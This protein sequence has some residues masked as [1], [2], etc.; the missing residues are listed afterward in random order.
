VACG[1]RHS[2]FVTAEGALLVCGRHDHGVLG[3]GQPAPSLEELWSAAERRLYAGSGHHRG[4]PVQRVPVTLCASGV[5]RVACGPAH[6][7]VCTTAGQ[8]RTTCRLVVRWAA[9]SAE[10]LPWSASCPGARTNQVVR[11]LPRAY[12]RAR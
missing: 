10:L 5:A 2:A 11:E 9:A 12:H 6:T 8:V 3:L 1:A 4:E 7:L